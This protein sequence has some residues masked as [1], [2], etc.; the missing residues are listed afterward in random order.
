LRRH[1]EHGRGDATHP[2]GVGLVGC[3]RIAQLFHLRALAT[4]P[5]ARLVAVADVDATRLAEARHVAHDATAVADYSEMLGNPDV[6][7]VVICLPT[8]LHAEAAIAAFEGGRH[9][10]VEKPLARDPR[11]AE[12]IVS[13]WRRSGKVG[14]MGFNFRFHPLVRAARRE[15]E[16]GRIGTPLAARTTFCAAARPLPAWKAARATGGGALLELASHHVDLTPHLLASEVDAV[17]ATIRSARSEHDTAAVE[18]R[19]RSGALVQTFVSMAA[20]EEDRI[21][22]YGDDGKLT[23]DRYRQRRVVATARKRDFSRRARAVDGVRL[24]AA[25]PRMLGD[26]LRPP[27]ERSFELALGRFVDAAR[28]LGPV[29]VDLD[30]G[31]RSLVVID[32][33]ERSAA[34]GRAV[35]VSAVSSTTRDAAGAAVE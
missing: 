33:A 4:L 5:G 12:E 23:L 6:E 20:V 19:L 21:E 35:E 22:L 3:G 16:R 15:L 32:A 11:E 10:Y 26:A 2:L 17:F 1:T 34:T 13:A 18:L 14:A 27:V 29:E 9:V 7:A 25:T 28:S 8:E 31:Y 24:L 30:D